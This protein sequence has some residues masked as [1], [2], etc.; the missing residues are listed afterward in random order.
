MPKQKTHG[1]TKDRV[2]LTKTGKVLVR[3]SFG[4]HNLRKK[5]EARKRRIVKTQEVTGKQARTI[6][7]KIGA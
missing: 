2:K 6:K 3:H 4:N 7:R 5:S 1:G